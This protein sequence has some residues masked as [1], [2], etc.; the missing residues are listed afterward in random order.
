MDNTNT[1]Y[2]CI[3]EEK[4]LYVNIITPE[5]PEQR[6]AQLSVTFSVNVNKVHQELEKRGV[7]VSL[8]SYLFSL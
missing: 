7:V 4:D 6:G 8:N 3:T 1:M 5:D 2:H